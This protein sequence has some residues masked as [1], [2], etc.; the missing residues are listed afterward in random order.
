MVPK[1]GIDIKVSGPLAV[2][3]DLKDIP[4]VRSSGVLT[5]SRHLEVKAIRQALAPRQVVDNTPAIVYGS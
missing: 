2:E 5:T 4:L 3:D 1:P